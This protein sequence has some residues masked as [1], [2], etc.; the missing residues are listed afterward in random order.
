MSDGIYVKTVK[1]TEPNIKY[2]RRIFGLN[3]DYF[4]DMS[5]DLIYLAF[6]PNTI[7]FKRENLYSTTNHQTLEFY[8]DKVLYNIIC[9]I[10]S[11]I[12]SLSG[13]AKFLTEI[14]SYVSKNLTLTNL[15]L[16]HKACNYV[17]N[18]NYTIS[19]SL[20]KM[21]NICADSFEA[22]IGALNYHLR[23]KKLNSIEILTDWILKWTNFPFYLRRYIDNTYTFENMQDYY[24]ICGNITEKV[25]KNWDNYYNNIINKTKNS[26]LISYYKTLLKISIFPE[27]KLLLSEKNRSNIDYIY[28]ILGYDYGPILFKDNLYVCLG[29]EENNIAEIAYGNTYE[30]AV[31]NAVNYLILAGYIDFPDSENFDSEYTEIEDDFSE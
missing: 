18:Q 11:D 7:N 23:E 9:N 12:F 1:L 26:S 31:Y 6:T 16:S 10:L 25:K 24:I 8:G 27:Y 17:N 14:T 15:M 19:T 4:S 28:K 3:R 20:K 13:N 2:I 29:P 21:H 5:D 30:Q 22:L